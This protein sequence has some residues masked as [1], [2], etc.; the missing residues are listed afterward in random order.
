MHG[1]A[2]FLREYHASRQAVIFSELTD[3][4]SL[5]LLGPLFV[6]LQ[7]SFLLFRTFSLHKKFLMG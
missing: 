3:L 1:S 7:T 4:I 5:F 2:F 6:G